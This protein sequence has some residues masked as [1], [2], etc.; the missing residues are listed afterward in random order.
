MRTIGQS[1]PFGNSTR[2]RLLMALS[3]LGESYPRELARLLD[4]R[5]F[6]VQRA[7]RSLESDA[8]VAARSMG[9]TR[10]Y[11]LNPSY[12]AR[13]ELERFVSRLADADPGLDQRIESVRRRPRRTGK[14][15]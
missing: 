13:A 8:I 7:L 4:L 9:R 11:R 15:L 5:L 1:S 12:F 2:T 3:R 6:S 10:L 14:T